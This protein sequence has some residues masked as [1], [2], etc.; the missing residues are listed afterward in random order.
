MTSPL[1]PPKSAAREDE[2]QQQLLAEALY[3]AFW[4]RNEW[5]DSTPFA[6][7]AVAVRDMWAAIAGDALTFTAPPAQSSAR[8]LS[9]AAGR[10]PGDTPWKRFRDEAPTYDGWGE[11]HLLTWNV[12][13][14]AYDLGCIDSQWSVGEAI[15]GHPDD[16]WRWL[17]EN[18]ERL[19]P[20][21][22]SADDGGEALSSEAPP[23]SPSEASGPE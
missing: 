14:G 10:P 23:L 12:R 5:R 7:Q 2:A 17:D 18:P 4:Q 22:S 13:A 21:Q 15:S 1:S 19:F 20:A 16:F 11:R 9:A 3:Y 8:E 6:Q